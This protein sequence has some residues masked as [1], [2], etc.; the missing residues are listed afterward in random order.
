MSAYFPDLIGKLNSFFLDR[1]I[2]TFLFIRECF[3]FD[4]LGGGLRC[5]SIGVEEQSAV[6]IIK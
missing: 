4:L 6:K 5:S 1:N 2:W 3:L